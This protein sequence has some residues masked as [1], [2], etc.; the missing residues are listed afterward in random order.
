MACCSKRPA[1]PRRGS[2]K[3]PQCLRDRVTPPRTAL[4]CPRTIC[5]LPRLPGR[6]RKERFARTRLGCARSHARRLEHGIQQFLNIGAIGGTVNC[7]IQQ[8]ADQRPVGSDPCV[9]Q[10]EC[11]SGSPRTA[12][13]TYPQAASRH[14]GLGRPT[15]IP[16]P[17]G[18]EKRAGDS[19]VERGQLRSVCCGE[20]QK[21]GIGCPRCSRTPFRKSTRGLIVGEL[22][23]PS[24]QGGHHAGQRLC[25]LLDSHAASGPLHRD[26]YE[27]EF[28]DGGGHQLYRLPS[29]EDAN[30]RR[31]PLMI[32]V[33]GPAPGD[34]DVD[35]QQVIH[36]KSD[37]SSRT[38]SVVSGG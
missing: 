12:A 10:V 2:E 33:I 1:R 11:G 17:W 23:V 16:L 26:P 38:A 31:G 21:V 15:S 35:V 4:P 37:S 6:R 24:A 13:T 19:C 36:G 20:L 18:N 3:A 30:P 27:A 25:C 34:Q 7:V 32:D 29:S 14:S 9:E 5:W 8:E 28:R 22:D